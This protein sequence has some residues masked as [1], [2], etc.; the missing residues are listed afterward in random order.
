MSALALVASMALALGDANLRNCSTEPVEKYFFDI[1]TA[2]LNLADCADA[3]DMLAPVTK[4]YAIRV[5]RPMDGEALGDSGRK[6]LER[7]LGEGAA[8]AAFACMNEAYVDMQPGDRVEVSFLPGQ[9]LLLRM[10]DAVLAECPSGDEGAGYFA[11]WFGEK[12]FDEDL[13]DALT[14]N[15]L[16]RAAGTAPLSP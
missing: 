9:G 16:Q 8:L 12:P 5:V 13:R 2:E 3:A 7:N 14:G 1:G 10:N 4:Q 15:A 11:I 6:L